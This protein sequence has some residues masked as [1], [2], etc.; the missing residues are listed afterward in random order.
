MLFR[1]ES[2]NRKNAH[3]VP[4]DKLEHVDEDVHLVNVQELIHDEDRNKDGVLD[5]KVSKYEVPQ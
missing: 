4:G 5:G 1:E 3:K 2:L